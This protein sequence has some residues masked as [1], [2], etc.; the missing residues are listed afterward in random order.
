[1]SQLVLA[2]SRAIEP[3]RILSGLEVAERRK[4]LDRVAPV[5]DIREMFAFVRAKVLRREPVI[6]TTTGVS[7][8]MF[9][10]R[11]AANFAIIRSRLRYSRHFGRASE[12]LDS[13]ENALTRRNGV[14]LP[15]PR[16]VT[17]NADCSL[18]LWW[19]PEGG[20]AFVRLEGRKFFS[21]LGGPKGLIG[22]A[23]TSELLDLL[24]LHARIQ[25]PQLCGRTEQQ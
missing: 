2:G 11:D 18:S 3:R 12:R 21:L 20:G 9:A 1:M 8:A 24:A 15:T 25:T 13:L 7:E 10:P 17:Q 4:V 16:K 23:I 19:G 6:F 5:Q 22:T 14:I